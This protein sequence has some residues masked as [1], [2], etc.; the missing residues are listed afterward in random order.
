MLLP[1]LCQRNLFSLLLIVQST[2]PKDCLSCLLQASRK[3]PNPDLWVQRLRDLLQA[4]ME[5]RNFLT[6]VLLSSTCQ[7]QLKHLCQKI[8]TN[9]KSNDNL[10]RKLNWFVKLENPCLV[11]AGNTFQSGSQIRKKRKA[12]EESLNLEEETRRKRSQLEINLDTEFS[13]PQPELQD[14]GTESAKN[15]LVLDTFGNEDVH[16]QSNINQ[17]SFKEDEVEKRIVSQ[18]SKHDTVTEVPSHMKVCKVF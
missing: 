4:G 15:E 9:A 14:V 6:P 10:E 12:S 17:F 16:C 3:D 11:P 8:M 2:V 5:E 18:S 7:Q 1:V 13:Q